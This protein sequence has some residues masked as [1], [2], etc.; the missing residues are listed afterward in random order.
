[1]ALAIASA[2]GVVPA[3]APAPAVAAGPGLT[4]VGAANYDVQPDARKV[5]VT[6][7]LTA[8]NHLKDS[9]TKRYFFRVVYLTVVPGTS[10][11]TLT[12]ATAGAKPKVTSIAATET[13]TNLKLDF[14]ANLPAG[15]TANL[16]LTFELRDPGGAPDRAVWISHSLVSFSAWAVAAPSTAGAT[17]VVRFPDG[18][19]VT[20]GRGPLS[21]PTP[22]GTGHQAWSSGAL[23][24]PLD[25]VADITADR[26]TDYEETTR[27]APMAGGPATI[28]L[29]AWP[30]DPAWRDRVGALVQRALPAFEREIGVPW[31]VD[32]PLAVHEALVR[33]TGGYAGLF[34]PDDRRIE[35][36]Y[37]AP[38][39]VVLHELAH[40]WFNGGLVAERWVAEGFAAYYA[41]L[42]A[43]ELGVDPA[44][45]PTA[46]VADAAA[47]PLNAWSPS[48]TEPPESERWAYAASLEL[49][50]QVA[51]RASPDELHAIWKKAAGR[52]AAYQ[53]DANGAEL[54]PGP[55]DWRGL[56]DL[57]EVGTGSDY[58]D[59]WRIWVARPDDVAALADRATARGYYARSVALAGD[60]RLPPMP[61]AAMGAWR[62]D[63]ARD[64]LAAA[65]GVVAQRNLL[66]ASAEAAGVTLPGTLREAFEGDGGVAAA[67]VEAQAEQATVTAIAAAEA[68]RPTEHGA[69]ERLIIGI[70]LLLA[71]PDAR[72]AEARTEL[73]AGDLEAAYAAAQAADTGW[74]SA[75][76]VGRSRIVSV[77][78]LLLALVVFAGLIRQRH[79]RSRQAPQA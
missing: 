19:S 3:L 68:A 73:A 7:Q 21:G 10:N 71:D 61:R 23:D 44:A 72:L 1:V 38:D 47:I 77:V 33:S 56:L 27:T 54:A 42:V 17:V 55:P 43:K 24:V 12:S 59:L 32:G 53:P 63:V 70:G 45:P 51:G 35:I 78:L 40:A 31:P 14:G 36:A 22:A 58:T 11:F 48:A 28:L 34:D 4:V 65:D 76:R 41:E 49:A 6:V 39:G 5:A 30:D 50:R 9:V 37:A 64:Q 20:V 13:Y 62:F 46:S 60:W 18:Y 2:V 29:R 57:L 66:E 79:R 67:A 25:Y 16:T 74:T 75:P 15:K 8:T 52:L 69:G 26:P